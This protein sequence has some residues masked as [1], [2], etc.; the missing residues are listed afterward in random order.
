MLQ[1]L[2]ESK[3]N[4]LNL[5]IPFLLAIDELNYFSSRK[6]QDCFN[7]TKNILNEPKLT[8]IIGLRVF[9]KVVSVYV[10]VAILILPYGTKHL[11]SKVILGQIFQY[12]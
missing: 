7:W 4:L 6:S 9:L 12:Q 1:N 2:L 11:Y 3:Y 5:F 10:F 8:H